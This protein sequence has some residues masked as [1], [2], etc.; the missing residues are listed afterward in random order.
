MAKLVDS[1]AFALPNAQYAPYIL[2]T[3]PFCIISFGF[4]GNVPSLVKLYGT[5]GIH[6]ITRSIIIGTLFAVLLYVFWLAVTMGNISRAEFPPIIAKGGNIDVFV[7]AISGLFS[8]RYMDLIL[9]FSVTSPWPAL[10]W[11]Q[12]L[13]CLITLLI[14][15]T[16]R[17]TAWGA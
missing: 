6:N 17:I 14:Y 15:S 4:H 2:M 10:Y 5:D 3:L 7:E 9:T 11:R 8:S 13:A 1:V 16:S 12:R